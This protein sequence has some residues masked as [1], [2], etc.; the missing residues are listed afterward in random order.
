MQYFNALFLVFIGG[1][2]GSVARYG[3]GLLIFPWSQRFPLATMLANATACLILGALTSMSMR[4]LL[5]DPRRLLLATGFCGGFSTF[6]TF[7]YE[8]WSLFQT[9][10]TANAILNIFLSLSVCFLSLLLG[11]KIGG[12]GWGQSG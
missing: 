4:G 12:Q 9:G 10:Q 7:T 1:G 2:L 8:T 6:S 5:D 11:M 3:M